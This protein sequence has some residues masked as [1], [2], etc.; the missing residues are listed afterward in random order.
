MAKGGGGN[1]TYVRDNRG[2]F[3]SSPGGGN[4][5]RPKARPVARGANRITRNNAGRITSVGGNG[6]T[7]RGGRLRTAGGKLRATQ[8][9]R[10]GKSSR[11]STV[12]K[13]RGLKPGTVTAPRTQA[14][15]RAGRPLG[16]APALTR[17]NRQQSG[18]MRPPLS[19]K[20][21]IKEQGG[22]AWQKAGKDR[23]YFNNISGRAGLELSLYK[24][25][26]ISSA[27]LRGQGISNSEGG[28]LSAK[29][30]GSKVFYDKG[31]R[32]I[33]I[34]KP[35]G[36]M[37]DP[38]RDKSTYAMVRKVARQIERGSRM[39]VKRQRKTRSR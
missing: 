33:H 10:V 22:K 27:S 34:Q 6:A 25:G 29:L 23:I 11:A 5:G 13:P 26:N 14:S 20:R 35:Y 9:A 12:G 37:A 38:R 7:A 2:R 28:R 36:V 1:R 18:T 17:L 4:G 21:M 3:A 32:K 19:P 30:D 39:Q 15:G 31:T 8:F 24:S 16:G